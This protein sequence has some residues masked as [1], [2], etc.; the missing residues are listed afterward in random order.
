MLILPSFAFAVDY[1]QNLE[2][3]GDGGYVCAT[4][5]TLCDSYFLTGGNT[6]KIDSQSGYK[7]F[8]FLWFNVAST[9]LPDSAAV[10][11]VYMWMYRIPATTGFPASYVY[12]DMREK[13]WVDDITW[14]TFATGNSQP[15]PPVTPQYFYCPTNNAWCT[16]DITAQYKAWRAGQ[17]PNGGFFMQSSVSSGY[18]NWFYG[19]HPSVPPEFK[20]RLQFQMVAGATIPVPGAPGGVSATAGNQS[21]AVSFIAPTSAGLSPV[22]SYIV[23]ASP[24]GF[25]ARAAT[26]PIQ[27]TGL[28]ANIAYTFT[29]KAVNGHGIGATSV[30]SNA[31]TPSGQ[32][33]STARFLSFPL[34]ENYPQGAYTPNKVNSVVDHDMSQAYSDLNGKILSFSGELFQS[35]ATYT[36]GTQACYPKAG[37]GAWSETLR[38]VYKGTGSVGAGANNCLKDAALNYEAHPGFDYVAKT[39]TPVFAAAAGTV[40]PVSGG[41]VNKGFSTCANLGAV[42]IDHGNGYITQYLHLS[43]IKVSPGKVVK[44]GDAIGATGSQGTAAPHLHFEVLKVRPGYANN[45]LPASYATVDPYGFNASQWTDILAQYN[46]VNSVCLWKIGCTNP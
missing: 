3:L 32:T 5:P 28:A 8:N 31:V 7:W 33:P 13:R 42:G 36:P 24:G 30:A 18:S 27:V 4:T 20:P 9:A 2:D 23:T 44:E 16:V 41:C 45:Y 15:T 12:L 26:S 35:N 22:T 19:P 11:K 6:M 17:Y 25:T 34:M 40:V 21:A 43:Q 29:V 10:D 37:G 46:G 38:S 39:G 1:W 14:Q